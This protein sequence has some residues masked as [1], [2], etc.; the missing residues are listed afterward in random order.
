MSVER[1]SRAGITPPPSRSAKVGRSPVTSRGMRRVR[2][3]GDEPGPCGR[4]GRCKQML[5]R[6]R[7]STDGAGDY[8]T[9]DWVQQAPCRAGGGAPR[10][11]VKRSN[12][13]VDGSGRGFPFESGDARRR[14]WIAASGAFDRS[15]MR[16]RS[17]ARAEARRGQDFRGYGDGGRLKRSSLD[18]D[19]RRRR[20]S[21]TNQA[22]R[23]LTRVRRRGDDGFPGLFAVASN[24]VRTAGASSPAT[25]AGG[26]DLLLACSPRCPPI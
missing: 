5:S 11:V 14:V 6:P 13:G 23:E 19:L 9:V 1:V 21:K 18:P 16:R 2:K 25:G 15:V 22:N 12:G 20:P 4:D 10:P 17:R 24:C 26:D 3:G 7:T 8:I